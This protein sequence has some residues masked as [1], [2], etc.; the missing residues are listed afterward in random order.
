MTDMLSAHDLDRFAEEYYLNG[1]ID[2]TDIEELAQR[3]SIPAILRATLH[4][5]RL[6]ELGYGTGLITRAGRCRTRGARRGGKRPPRCPRP[7]APCP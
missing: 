3:H 7:R 5:P 4:S 2:D 6:L 1:E